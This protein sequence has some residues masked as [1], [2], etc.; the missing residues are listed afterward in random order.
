[1]VGAG[2]R[3]RK[4][5]GLVGT[6]LVEEGRSRNGVGRGGERRGAAG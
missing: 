6:K 4:G 1:M 2:T 5:R 3:K